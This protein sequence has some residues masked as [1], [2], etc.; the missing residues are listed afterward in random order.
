MIDIII[1]SGTVTVLKDGEEDFIGEVS[2]EWLENYI[3]NL[4]E[5]GYDVN[6]ST[7]E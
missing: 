6:I 2:T 4:K 3:H 1:H 5:D 7:L